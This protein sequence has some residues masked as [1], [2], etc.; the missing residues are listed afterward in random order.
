MA[1]PPAHRTWG[2]TVASRMA[3]HWRASWR[4][5]VVSGI[6]A[7]LAWTLAQRL[8]G[9]PQP[10][11]ALITAIVCLA[12][13]LP[14]YNIQA[15]GVLLGVVTGVVVGELALF[16]P[17]TFPLVRIAA[18]ACIAILVA[19][20]YGY[21]PVVPIQAGVSAVL[22]LTLGATTAGPARLLDVAL[23][24]T[25][26]ILF[27]QLFLPPNPLR[28]IQLAARG[29]VSTLAAGFGAYAVALSEND[30][31][32]AVAALRLVSSAHDNIAALI[33]DVQAARYAGLWPLRGHLT[34]DQIKQIMA[35]R[36]GHAVRLL[37][38][39]LLFASDVARALKNEHELAP[40]ALSQRL[41]RLAD[42]CASLAKG[43]PANLHALRDDP[44]QADAITPPWR[45]ATEDLRL[46]ETALVEFA[47]ALTPLIHPA[48][49][50]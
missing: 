37:A 1:T 18:A 2:S 9:H 26:G 10:L 20:S 46:I 12:P 7:A 5:A 33:T 38:L 45:A 35:R 34:G 42:S 39:T 47:D 4:S 30:R 31:Q 23:G 50:P 36:D 25:I 24:T 49:T 44:I 28:A 29:F 41:Q 22:V 21:P 48:R 15:L 27:S 40:G 17:D 19:V 13:G 8:F 32:K 11:F 16:A 43:E 6:A 3:A 14:S